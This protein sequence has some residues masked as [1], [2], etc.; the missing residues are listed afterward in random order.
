MDGTGSAALRDSVASLLR[1]DDGLEP[2]YHVL[3]RL[4]DASAELRRERRDVTPSFDFLDTEFDGPSV[5]D[6]PAARRVADAESGV[7]SA[8]T[9]THEKL[10]L[11][12]VRIEEHPDAATVWATGRYKPTPSTSAVPNTSATADPNHVTDRWGFTETDV[13]PAVEFV[14]LTDSERTLVAEF[15]P[16]AVERND[17]F[18][19]FRSNA[20]KTNSLVDRLG[21]IRLPD[22]DAMD[23]D[24]QRYV[25]RKRQAEAL[26]ERL[27]RV[28]T[29]IDTIVYDCYGLSDDEI[30]IVESSLLN[31]R[32]S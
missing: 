8:T 31:D 28:T 6:H 2:V 11:G 18:A 21:A 24:L 15:V 9:R 19:G 20:T 13:L 3:A 1:A 5:D 10:R 7:L 27:G 30:R 12:T 4:A 14:G 22:I 32:P 17:G 25:E 23:D 16:Y 26:T 29:A